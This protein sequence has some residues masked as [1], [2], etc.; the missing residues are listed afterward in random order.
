VE[1]K[2]MEK[3]LERGSSIIFTAVSLQDI[4]S[5]IL[6]IC[7]DEIPLFHIVVS[8]ISVNLFSEHD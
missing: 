1:N 5:K 4:G 6:P 3:R 8:F 7:G 2:D